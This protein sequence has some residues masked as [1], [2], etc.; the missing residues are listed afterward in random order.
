MEQKR[1]TMAERFNRLMGAATVG[2]AKDYIIDTIRGSARIYNSSTNTETADLLCFAENQSG[3]SS[4]GSNYSQLLTNQTSNAGQLP[5]GE[6]FLVTGLKFSLVTPQNGVEYTLRHEVISTLLINAVATFVT[7]NKPAWSGVLGTLRPP[8]SV[9]VP[10]TD[11]QAST[12]YTTS[13][14]TVIPAV[15]GVAAKTYYNNNSI[16]VD[17]EKRPIAIQSQYPFDMRVNTG[18]IIEST[19]NL[20]TYHLFLMCELLGIRER[21]VS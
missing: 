18:K 14:A 12:G 16:K 3:F 19:F 8:T 2:G 11:G 13:G 10:G 7:S 15:A 21:P 5:A 20:T 17:L 4:Y 9:V 1:E 6:R